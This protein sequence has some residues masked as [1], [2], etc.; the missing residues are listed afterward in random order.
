M[1]KSQSI[2]VIIV[3]KDGSL[4]NL[5]IKDYKEED[6]FKNAVLKNRTILK[7][8]LSGKLNMM[9]PIMAL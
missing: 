4:Q 8:I 6:L 3:K 5:T 9:E 2:S 1:I 7:S